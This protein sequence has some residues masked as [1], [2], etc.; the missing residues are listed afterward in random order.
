MM[1]DKKLLNCG[2]YRFN[3]SFSSSIALFFFSPFLDCA[4]LVVSAVSSI[5][6]ANGGEAAK[7]LER[8]TGLYS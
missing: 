6:E 5:R 1:N 8:N 2:I 3:S 7:P 4:V